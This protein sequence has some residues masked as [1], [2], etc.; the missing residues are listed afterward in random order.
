MS[1]MRTIRRNIRKQQIISISL[2]EGISKNRRYLL[3]LCVLPFH[4]F[5]FFHLCFETDE[6]HLS[7]SLNL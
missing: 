7:F 6:Y 5:Y 4:E 3:L 1:T 2:F